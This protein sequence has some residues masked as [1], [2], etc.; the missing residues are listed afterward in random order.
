TDALAEAPEILEQDLPEDPEALAFLQYTSGSTSTPKGVMVTHANLMH[1]EAMIG[2][3]FQQSADSVVVGWL[4][5]YHDMGLIGNVL[6]PLHAG[7]RCVLMAPAA[8]LQRP[9]RWLEAVSRY[10]GTSEGTTSGGPSFAYELCVRRIPPEQREGLDLR[11]WRVAFNGAEPVRAE[12]MARFAEAF[13]PCGFDPA[14]FYPCYGLAEATLFVSGGEAGSLPREEPV[15]GGRP[16]VS[17]GHVWGG[18]RIAI[19]DPE[20]GAEMPPGAEGEIWVAGP[21][22]AAGYWRNPEATE[23]DFRARLIGREEPFLRT[24]DLGVMVGEG[25]AGDL[26]VTGRIKD[27]VILRGRNHYPQ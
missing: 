15:T 24:G 26:Y 1:N 5:L 17:C 6:Q 14:A 9:R 8:F 10:G 2:Q 3:A 22:V 21:S 12:T 20:T 4:P 18:Q 13:A 11:S 27:L 23:R 16:L 7:C 19:A 25:A